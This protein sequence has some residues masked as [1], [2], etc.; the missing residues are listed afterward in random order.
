MN[1][2]LVAVLMS[3]IGLLVIIV[4]CTIVQINADNKEAKYNKVVN[5]IS[6]AATKCI[7]DKMC[8]EGKITLKELYSKKYL[9]K[10]KNPKTGKYFGINSYINYP[11]LSFYIK[12]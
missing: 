5:D 3:V 4:I 1:K 10:E 12:K 2:K 7:S 11:E 9:E 8:S 6:K